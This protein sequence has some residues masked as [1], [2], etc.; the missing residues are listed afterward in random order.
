ME[1]C[2]MKLLVFPTFKGFEVQ[3]EE[4]KLMLEDFAI[5]VVEVQ[6]ESGLRVVATA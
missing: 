4:R 2:L 3:L 6:L 5:L 1:L